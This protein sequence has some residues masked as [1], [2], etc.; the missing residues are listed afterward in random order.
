MLSQSFSSVENSGIS[1]F[2]QFF[3]GMKGQKDK[4][5]FST[6][7]FMAEMFLLVKKKKKKVKTV[8]SVFRVTNSSE[9]RCKMSG[10]TISER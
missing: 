6:I 9:S 10:R 8:G 5:I 7:I 4:K 1:G 3:T 2:F